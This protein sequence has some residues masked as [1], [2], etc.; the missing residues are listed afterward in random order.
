[1]VCLPDAPESYN[2]KADLFEF[3]EKM[4]V[5]KWDESIVLTSKMGK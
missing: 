3:I 5:C 4:P 1:L 2:K